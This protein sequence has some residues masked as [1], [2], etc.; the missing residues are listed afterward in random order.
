MAYERKNIQAMAAYIPGEQID[1]PGIIKLNTNENP[2]PPSPAVSQAMAD[3]DVGRLRQYP[4]PTARKLQDAIAAKHGLSADNVIVTN[5]GDEL[6][7]MAI[8]TFVEVSEKVAVARPT[9]TLYQ[10][11][12]SAHGCEMINFEL[13]DNYHLPENYTDL[14]NSSGARLTFL[15]NPHAPSGTLIDINAIAELASGYGGVLLLDEAYIDFVD[16]ELAYDSAQLVRDHDNVLILRTFSKGY[17]LAGLR[18]AYGLASEALIGPLMKT[19]DSYNTDLISQALARASIEDQDYAR[20]TWRVVRE[21]RTRLTAALRKLG[22]TVPDSQSNFV[23]ATVPGGGAKDGAEKAERIY[24][25]LK[26]Q[27]ILVRYFKQEDRLQDKL[28]I[29]IGTPEDNQR[30]LDALAGMMVGR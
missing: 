11:L 29:T 24:L 10:V 21:E 12:T 30:L 3:C 2:Y 26:E 19:K 1:A 25:A 9:Y 5:G 16:P 22:Y 28:R 20:E 23:L 18:M 13:D 8:A 17:S 14:L 27:G 15:V 6:L 4:P 7:R